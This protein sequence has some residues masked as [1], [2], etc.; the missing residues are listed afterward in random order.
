MRP[1]SFWAR[2]V[3]VSRP[4]SPLFRLTVSPWWTEVLVAAGAQRGRTDDSMTMNFRQRERDSAKRGHDI[5]TRLTTLRPRTYTEARRIGELF[6]NGKPVIMDLS[7][8]PDSDARRLVDFAA[9]LIFGLRGS[10][11]KIEGKVFLLIPSGKE[12]SAI[13][14]HT[15]RGYGR[16]TVTSERGKHSI[17]GEGNDGPDDSDDLLDLLHAVS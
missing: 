16:I 13:V 10:I 8:M 9:G 14:Q 2:I 7:G 5:V 15:A 17:P 12:A 6:R 11:D 1:D 4:G 3:R